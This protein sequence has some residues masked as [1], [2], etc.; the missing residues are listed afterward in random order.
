MQPTAFKDQNVVY[1]KDQPEYLPLPA[2]QQEKDPKGTVV[3]CWKATFIERL[4]ILFTG[5]LYLSLRILFTGRLS[6]SLLSFNKPL[7]PNRIYA[8]KPIK[9]FKENN[10]AS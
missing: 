6:L 8:E 9:Y 1:A 5:R 2:W 10:H 7:T 4:R 3:C